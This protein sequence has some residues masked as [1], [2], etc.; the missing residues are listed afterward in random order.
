MVAFD[1]HRISAWRCREQPLGAGQ[2]MVHVIELKTDLVVE[3][4]RQ[5]GLEEAAGIE[6]IGDIPHGEG[7]TTADI[8]VDR[9]VLGTGRYGHKQNQP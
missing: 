5:S 4:R 8:E 1:E 7:H 2:P 6:G 3:H 9:S